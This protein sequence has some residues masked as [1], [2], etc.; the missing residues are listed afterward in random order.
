MIQTAGTPS[1]RRSWIKGPKI[2]DT[3]I[4]LNAYT[5]KNPYNRLGKYIDMYGNVRKLDLVKKFLED[6]CSSKLDRMVRKGRYAIKNN[7]P[8]VIQ[9]LYGKERSQAVAELIGDGFHCS[10]V[11]YVHREG[12]LE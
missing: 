9:C 2:P 1:A 6:E 7:R 3:G 11:F 5:L 8:V 4:V 10:K 12:R